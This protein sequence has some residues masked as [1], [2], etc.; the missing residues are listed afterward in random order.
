MHTP[1]LWWIPA[2]PLLG[3]AVCGAIHFLTLS[4][5]KADPAAA[6]PSALAPLVERPIQPTLRT[7]LRRKRRSETTLSP[8]LLRVG[9]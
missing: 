2:L 6:G 3:A 4:A 5:R 8:G 1:W 7:V 9:G